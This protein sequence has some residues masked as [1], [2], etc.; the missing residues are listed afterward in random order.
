MP[1]ETPVADNS[2]RTNKSMYIDNLKKEYVF[3]F[4]TIQTGTI[5][6]LFDA[7]KE[8]LPDC[9]LIITQD[10]IHIE[11]SDSKESIVVKLFLEAEKI[12]QSGEYHCFVDDYLVGIDMKTL[13]IFL[14]NAEPRHIITFCVE[15][16]TTTNNSKENFLCIRFDDEDSHTRECHYLTA[17]EPNYKRIQMPPYE[18]KCRRLMASD[19]FRR[20]IKTMKN[21]GEVCK[22]TNIND[23]ELR[24]STV[25]YVG[26]YNVSLICK[27]SAAEPTILTEAEEKVAKKKQKKEPAAEEPTPAAAVAAPN[28]LVVGDFK[29]KYLEYLVR[30]SNLCPSVLIG[31]DHQKPLTVEFQVASLGTLQYIIAQHINLDID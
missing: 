22:L 28:N 30:P 29:L 17:I 24:L 12:N 9:V 10:G 11:G 15:R 23:N 20:Y 27:P 31:L 14:K 19:A 2:K 26:S 8:V 21:I 5:K 7:I 13:N 25:G 6:T 4:R 3:W 18:Y 16:N 1:E